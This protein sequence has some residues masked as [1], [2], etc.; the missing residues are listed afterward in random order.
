[1]ENLN[2]HKQKLYCLIIAG[3]GLISLFLAWK[4]AQ[5]GRR[6]DEGFGFS[7]SKN[8]FSGMGLIAVLGIVGVIA[9]SFMGDKT[10]AYEGQSKQIALG[11]FGAIALGAVLSLVTKMKILGY[12]VP[13]NPGIGAFLA[14]AVGAAGLL[15]LMGIVKIPDNKP[16]A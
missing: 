14:I 13:S 9:A 16:K 2:F 8:G 7:Y 1:M 15:F 10:K 4:V 5:G 12:P 3:V 6:M 11:S